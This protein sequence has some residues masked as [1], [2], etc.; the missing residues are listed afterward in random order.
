M[1]KNKHRELPSYESPEDA[2]SPEA[3]AEKKKEKMQ[4]LYSHGKVFKLPASESA[5]EFLKKKYPKE[6]K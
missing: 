2:E 3:P 4:T 1:G 5:E 6:Y